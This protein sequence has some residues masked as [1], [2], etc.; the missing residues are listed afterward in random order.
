MKYK[1]EEQV[2]GGVWCY[3]ELS[4]AWRLLY[5][6]DGSNLRRKYRN[7]YK[8]DEGILN[9][10]ITRKNPTLHLCFMI[11][12][13]VAVF[14]M[15]FMCRLRASTDWPSRISLKIMDSWWQRCQS[16]S[17]L[18]VHLYLCSN[19]HCFNL[20]LFSWWFTLF[21]RYICSAHV[22]NQNGSTRKWYS[23]ACA[24]SGFILSALAFVY[25]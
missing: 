19:C 25:I 1:C 18:Q 2:N 4:T 7:N 15:G 3:R 13:S 5:P 6:I 17:R 14:H 16:N 24:K 11:A 12:P 8:F 10:I 21:S 9:I 23:A 22:C 20:P